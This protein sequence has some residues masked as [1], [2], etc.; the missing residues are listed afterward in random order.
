MTN[1]QK[2]TLEIIIF[3]LI[4]LI[5]FGTMFYIQGPQNSISEYS[6]YTYT[7]YIFKFWL[8]ALIIGAYR[9]KSLRYTILPLIGLILFD[10]HPNLPVS[11]IIHN[12]NAILFFGITTLIFLLKPK[13]RL[14]GILMLFSYIFYYWSLYYGEIITITILYY[15][16]INKIIRL[17][18]SRY[19]GSN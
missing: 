11:T 14:T 19:S 7:P 2:I 5:C 8:F 13:N 4:G 12:I 1:K 9:N 15:H 17:N 3:S 18:L 10:S 16:F 6:H